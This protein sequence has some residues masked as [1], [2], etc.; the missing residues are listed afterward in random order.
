[1]QL[2]APQATSVVMQMQAALLRAMCT[3]VG[4]MAS[5]DADSDPGSR[6]KV[7]STCPARH[8]YMPGVGFCA[9]MWPL[10]HRFSS[11][12]S[13]TVVHQLRLWASYG[14]PVWRSRVNTS[15]TSCT[16]GQQY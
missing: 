3:G 9:S 14:H 15:I 1:M 2:A 10:N 16:L 4:R 7:A 8:S 5:A 11:D 13:H 6:L 12:V